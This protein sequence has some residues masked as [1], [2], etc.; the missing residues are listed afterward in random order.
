MA[1]FDDRETDEPPT[2]FI[3]SKVNVNP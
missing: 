1:L 3:H 2:G